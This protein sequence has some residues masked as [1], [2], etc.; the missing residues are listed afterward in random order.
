MAESITTRPAALQGLLGLQSQGRQPDVLADGVVP[1][2]SLLE[3]YKVAALDHGFDTLTPA[4]GVVNTTNALAGSTLP[5]VPVGEA[6]WFESVSLRLN[7]AAGISYRGQVVIVEPPLQAVA[8]CDM[9]AL[10]ANPNFLFLR[11][12]E[13][14]WLTAG[15]RLACNF[16]T[17]GGVPGAD[18]ALLTFRY[19]RFRA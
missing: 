11:C 5:L 2:I 13:G 10:A 8:L 15:A 18:S 7:P 1:E 9:S 12:R 6:W 17:V 14:F 16:D 19:A 3:L 4:L